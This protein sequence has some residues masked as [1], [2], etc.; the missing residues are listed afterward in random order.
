MDA[1]ATYEAQL[2]SPTPYQSRPHRVGWY[3]E[4]IR[5]FWKAYLYLLKRFFYYLAIL[6]ISFIFCIKYAWKN[7]FWANFFWRWYWSYCTKILWDA[8]VIL[9]VFS[10]S[11]KKL[12]INHRLCTSYKYGNYNKKQECYFSSQKFFSAAGF[13]KYSKIG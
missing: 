10:A 6:S 5:Y 13:W 1:L 12:A 11:L 7:L 8:A 4:N 9:S 2:T 3:S